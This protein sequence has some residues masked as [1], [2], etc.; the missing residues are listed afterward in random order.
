MGITKNSYKLHNP[1]YKMSNSLKQFNSLDQTLEPSDNFKAN[2][3]SKKY[4][5]PIFYY[6][7]E[8]IPN[9]STQ[10]N[11]LISENNDP[12]Y[13]YDQRETNRKTSVVNE[14]DL[15]YDEEFTRNM[16]EDEHKP[17]NQPTFQFQ[18][19]KKRRCKC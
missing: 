16:I 18:Q 2:E 10:S 12:V 11:Y 6:S 4:E 19:K 3:T 9:V 5:S 7:S 15:K 8:K 17:N 14:P 13:F 1:S